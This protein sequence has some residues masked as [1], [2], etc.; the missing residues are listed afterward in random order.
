MGSQNSLFDTARNV[1]SIDESLMVNS[2]TFIDDGDVMADISFNVS[3]ML[4]KLMF[5][6]RGF[7]YRQWKFAVTFLL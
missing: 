6:I 1:S 3:F 5:T 2:L 4:L 7:V